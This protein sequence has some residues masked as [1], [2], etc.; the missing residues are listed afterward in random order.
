MTIQQKRTPP[1]LLFSVFAGCGNIVFPTRFFYKEHRY[2]KL[3]AGNSSKN[4][5]FLRN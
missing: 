5:E 3:E 2:K 4:K 1:E